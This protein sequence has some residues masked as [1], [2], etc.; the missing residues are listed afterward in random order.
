MA[1]TKAKTATPASAPAHTFEGALRAQ[2]AARPPGKGLWARRLQQLLDAKPSRRRSR[3]LARLES[4]ARAYLV[5]E[6]LASAT[7][8]IDWSSIP[9]DKVLDFVLKLLL[10]IL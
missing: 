1:K 9:W 7:G 3:I 6:G 10:A 8:A 2:L 5:G 4:H